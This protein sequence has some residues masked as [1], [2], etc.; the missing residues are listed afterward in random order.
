MAGH[1]VDECQAHMGRPCGPPI[2]AASKGRL[3]SLVKSA[4]QYRIGAA[5]PGHVDLGVSLDDVAACGYVAVEFNGDIHAADVHNSLSD[6]IS[7]I[8][9]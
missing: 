8:P 2:R 6:Q 4:T 7:R 5:H 1:D 3:L 9:R